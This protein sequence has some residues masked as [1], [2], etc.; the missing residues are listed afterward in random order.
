MLIS[1]GRI[2]NFHYFNPK[3]M[4]QEF[5]FTAALLIML[6]QN[7]VGAITQIIYD[8]QGLKYQLS[9]TYDDHAFILPNP[10]DTPHPDYEEQKKM[11]DKESKRNQQAIIF[12]L[13][14]N[15]VLIIAQITIIYFIVR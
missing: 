12:S 10:P 9:R 8:L 14:Y 13:I 3:H 5:I 2:Y 7:M 6:V 4:T 11:F 1:I 15:H